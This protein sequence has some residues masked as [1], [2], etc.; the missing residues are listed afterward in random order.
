MRLKLAAFVLT[1]SALGLPQSF[2]SPKSDP[3]SSYCDLAREY[4]KYDHQIV[5]VRGIYRRG[6]EIASFYDAG[7]IQSDPAWVDWSPKLKQ[8][9]SPNLVSAMNALLDA[10]GRATVDA[11]IEF[12]GPKPVKIPP[13]TSPGLAKVMLSLNSR[14]GHMNQFRFRVVLVRLVGVE[15][16]PTATPWPVAAANAN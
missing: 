3:P 16:V 7:C 8:H 15:P 13:G 2:A 10:Q 1:L 5:H 12:D 6:G 14:Y 11:E 4:T 9:S